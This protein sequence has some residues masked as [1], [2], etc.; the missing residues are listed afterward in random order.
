M[1]Q[2]KDVGVAYFLKQL[3]SA[4]FSKGRRLAFDDNHAGD[5]SE[6]PEEV[7]VRQMPR[8]ISAKAQENAA[9]NPYRGR[10]ASPHRQEDAAESGCGPKQGAAGRAQG[11][12]DA[13]AEAAGADEEGRTEGAG[14]PA[15]ERTAA[16]AERG[17]EEG[18]TP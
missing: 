9:S 2:C 15:R 7:R 14:N 16:K 17:R 18:E 4:V 3:G 5:W 11:V 6:W 10:R 12:G 8:R 1:R 13:E